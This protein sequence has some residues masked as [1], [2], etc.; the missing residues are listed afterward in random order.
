MVLSLSAKG[1]T[2]GEIALHL[3]EVSSQEL[4][5]QTSAGC[6]VPGI[7]IR[8]ITGARSPLSTRAPTTSST[9]ARSTCAT[10]RLPSPEIMGLR[11]QVADLDRKLT[12]YRATLD[13]GADPAVVSQWITETQAR[14]HATEARLRT[15]EGA[16]AAARGCMTEKE[17]GA[18]VTAITDVVTVLRAADPADKA[19]LYAQLGLRLTFNPG[20]KTVIARLET[21][22]SCTKGSCPRGD[23]NTQARKFPRIGEIV[24]SP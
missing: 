4:S 10:P 16:Q 6:R 15:Q 21:G 17:I 3:T 12:S 2:H 18:M 23:L 7:T 24:R 11:D 20:P 19:A 22:Q 9:R 13:A 1:L 14:K 8:P 5:K